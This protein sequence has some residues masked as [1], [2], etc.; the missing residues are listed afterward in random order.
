MKELDRAILLV[1]VQND[2]C[3]RGKLAV[4]EG[5]G[6]VEPLNIMIEIAEKHGW[7]VIA[8]RDFHPN[9]TSHFIEHGGVWP[10]H[11][12]GG[13]T[14]ADFH[15]NLII[16][17]DTLIVS[18]GM[19]EDEN[20]YSAFD[21]KLDDGQALEDVLNARGI[22]KLY[23]GGL[24][25]DYCVKA[26]AIDAASKGFKTFLLEDAIRAVNINPMDGYNAIQDM[27]RAGVRPTNTQWE[28]YKA[29]NS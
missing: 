24:A 25:T 6:V 20:A 11:C 5:D 29:D 10:E 21:G 17:K 7:L 23:V 12:V 8:S 18:K 27:F 14:G 16:C 13:T 4:P 1:D 9:V 3:P 19:G 2:F 28:I 26:S 22:K 15:K